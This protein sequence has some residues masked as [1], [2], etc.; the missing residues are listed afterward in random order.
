[1][2]EILD[3]YNEVFDKNGKIKPCGRE[4]CKQLIIKMS[5]KFPN[6]D[7]GNKETGFM[8]TE[9]IINKIKSI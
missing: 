1:M 2:E 4:L 5:E 6:E 8:N 3:L 9:T 7:F